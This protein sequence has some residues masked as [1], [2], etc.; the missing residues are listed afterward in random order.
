MGVAGDGFRIGQS[1]GSGW[2][3]GVY[4]DGCGGTGVVKVEQVVGMSVGWWYGWGLCWGRVE[5]GVVVRGRAGDGVE[6]ED[7]C[8]G[9]AEGSGGEGGAWVWYRVRAFEV[10]RVDEDWTS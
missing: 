3:C 2:G 8:D 9:R 1:C 10:A 4:G 5:G 6:C 7:E